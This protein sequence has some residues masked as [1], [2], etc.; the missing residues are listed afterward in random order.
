VKKRLEPPL[1]YVGNFD[2]FPERL[3][4]LKRL[5]QTVEDFNKLKICPIE[6]IEE[7]TKDFSENVGI[8]SRQTNRL[9]PRQPSFAN[10]FNGFESQSALLDKGVVKCI[11]ETSST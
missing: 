4:V 9:N 10:D 2:A 11:D 3:R 8:A 1:H 6:G 7:I 5:C